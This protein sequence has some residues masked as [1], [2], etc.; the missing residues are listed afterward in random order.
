MSAEAKMRDGIIQRGKTWSYVVRERDPQTGKT[1]PRWVGGFPTRTAAKK[2]RDAARHA[3]NRGTYVPPAALTVGEW[4]D[5]WMEAHAVSLKPSTAASYRAN[6]ERY[7]QP[8]LRHERLQSLSPSRLS[9]VFRELYE[10]G[11]KGGRPLSARTVEFARAVLRKA[12]DDAVTERVLEVNPVV[13]TKRPKVDKPKHTV[14]DGEQLRAFVRHVEDQGDR[15]AALWILAAG[16]G[17]RRGELLA[18]R[19]D[20]VDL[21]GGVVHV[22]RSVTQVGKELHYGTPKNHER[23]SVAIDG[24][25]LAALRAWRK[26]QAAERLEW[27]PA[28]L[29]AEG[30]VFTW[31]N[32]SPVLGD[33]ASK[34]FVRAQA[35]AELPR[36]TLHEVRHTHA[37]ILLREGVPVHVVSARLGHKDASVTLNVYA[38]HIPEDHTRVL[39]VFSRAVWGA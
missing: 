20:Q 7:L 29:D 13:G 11:G 19:W 4:L 9:T 18:L 23:R 28:Y 33:Y 8:H 10:R 22:E 30:L 34:Q 35:G 6:I 14:W 5:T 3:V 12:L 21:E 32:G 17:M 15:F 25:T 37:S 36:L 31:E 1:K 24:Q 38:H 2:A 16:T 27:G 39:D 26:S